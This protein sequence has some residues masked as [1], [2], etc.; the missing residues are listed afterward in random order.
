MASERCE[1]ARWASEGHWH[2][3]E[4]EHLACGGDDM[5]EMVN[6]GCWDDEETWAIVLDDIPNLTWR[7]Q[8]RRTE[9]SAEIMA[10]AERL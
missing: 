1:Q 7:S 8:T 2:L 3:G 5:G 4:L 10:A 6:C 9:C